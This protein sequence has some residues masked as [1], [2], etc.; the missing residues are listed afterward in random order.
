LNLAHFGP[1]SGAYPSSFC[2][3]FDSSPTSS[4]GFDSFDPFWTSQ[5]VA[6]MKSVNWRNSDCQFSSTLPP[7]SGEKT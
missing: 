7:K 3:C 6:R 4:S 5:I 2:F 1:S